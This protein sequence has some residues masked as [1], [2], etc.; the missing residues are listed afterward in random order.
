MDSR[1]LDAWSQHWDKMS[2]KEGAL[3]QVNRTWDVIKRDAIYIT[4]Q[5]GLEKAHIV[6]DLCCGNGLL[7]YSVAEHCAGLRGIDLSPGQ[8]DRANQNELK[9]KFRDVQFFA[10]DITKTGFKDSSIDHAYCSTA[11]HYFPT[12]AYTEMMISEALR[13]LKPGGRLLITSVPDKGRFG[14]LLWRLIRN[15]NPNLPIETIEM[16][17]TQTTVLQFKRRLALVFRRF[18]GR[19]VESDEWRWYDQAFF[20]NFKHPE[21]GSV[22]THQSPAGEGLLSYRLDVLVTKR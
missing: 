3:D 5:L 19:K 11:A 4:E 13:Y 6:A 20:H 12:E 8:I 7:S 21:L 22:S 10:G 18:S 1:I 17:P 15:K 14:Y 16:Q 2:N 9:D